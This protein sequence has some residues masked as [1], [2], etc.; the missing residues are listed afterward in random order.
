M[1]LAITVYIYYIADDTID[2]QL[3]NYR[4]N[5]NYQEKVKRNFISTF[6]LLMI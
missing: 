1:F 6:P 2:D 5:R 4:Y 3:P